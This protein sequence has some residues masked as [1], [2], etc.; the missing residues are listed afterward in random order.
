M[1][2]MV[3]F[4]NVKDVLFFM[5]SIYFYRCR[6]A[7]PLGLCHQGYLNIFVHR[8]LIKLSHKP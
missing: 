3:L 6:P 4:E 2:H 5:D 7:P 1:R 8:Y